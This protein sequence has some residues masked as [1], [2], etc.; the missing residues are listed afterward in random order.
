MRSL[1]LF[2]AYGPVVPRYRHELVRRGDDLRGHRASRRHDLAVSHDERALLILGAD[3]IDRVSGTVAAAGE[4]ADD[5]LAA[6]IH[7]GLRTPWRVPLPDRIP[8]AGR[9]GRH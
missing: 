8:L 5:H 3:D 7:L 1:R 9:A 6:E 2:E 4:D